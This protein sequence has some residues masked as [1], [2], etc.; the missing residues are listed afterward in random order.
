[1]DKNNVKPDDFFVQEMNRYNQVRG[2]RGHVAKISRLPVAGNVTVSLSILF[3][4][5]WDR[6]EYPKRTR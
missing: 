4:R 6:L 5:L 1:M 3:L 2:K